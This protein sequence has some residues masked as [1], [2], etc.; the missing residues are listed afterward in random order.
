ML[1]PRIS[2]EILALDG[3]LGTAGNTSIVSPE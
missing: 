2:Q 1:I 3:A